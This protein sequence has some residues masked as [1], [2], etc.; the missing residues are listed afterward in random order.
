MKELKSEAKRVLHEARAQ[1]AEDEQAAAAEAKAAEKRERKE[2]LI[3]RK[4]ELT[5]KKV[6]VRVRPSLAR[7]AHLQEG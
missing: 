3:A 7:G 2:K 1:K 6:R 5:S 4:E